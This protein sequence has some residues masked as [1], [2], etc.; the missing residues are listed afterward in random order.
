MDK[1]SVLYQFEIET[2]SRDGNNNVFKHGYSGDCILESSA[3]WGARGL[4]NHV[5]TDKTIYLDP[6]GACVIVAHDSAWPCATRHPVHLECCYSHE[7]PS[8]EAR[9]SV[10][11]AKRTVYWTYSFYLITPVG[12]SFLSTHAYS[13]SSNGLCLLITPLL[14]RTRDVW[15][16]K[17]SCDYVCC[18]W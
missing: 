17:C 3:Q 6:S 14:S 11:A 18:A 10:M 16:A 9:N 7:E 8:T 12:R 15:T 1:V 13:A 2:R 5:E 4:L